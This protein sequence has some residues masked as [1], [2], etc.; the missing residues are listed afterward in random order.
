MKISDLFKRK[1]EQPEYLPI[2]A[3]QRSLITKSIKSSNANM[4]LSK[5]KYVL[6]YN[7][8]ATVNNLGLA[9]YNT[10]ESLMV[11]VAHYS[12]G[13]KTPLLHTNHSVKSSQDIDDLISKYSR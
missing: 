11:S 8:H 4:M 9:F 5:D 6:D 12:S 3:D 2:T 7:V 13:G 1:S 10:K